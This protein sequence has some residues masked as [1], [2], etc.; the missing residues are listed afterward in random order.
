MKREVPVAVLVEYCCGCCCCCWDR[1]FKDRTFE[2]EP[3]LLLLLLLLLIL[4]AVKGGVKADALDK[5]QA[6]AAVVVFQDGV[7]VDVCDVN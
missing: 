6:S 7:M 1:G 4:E 5:I 2:K 3:I